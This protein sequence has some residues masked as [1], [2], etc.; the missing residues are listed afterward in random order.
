MSLKDLIIDIKDA[1]V[2]GGFDC[3]VNYGDDFRDDELDQAI[4]QDSGVLR[5]LAPIEERPFTNEIM[6]NSQGLITSGRILT[7]VISRFPDTSIETMD[8]WLEEL[9][10]NEYGVAGLTAGMPVDYNGVRFWQWRPVEPR[11]QSAERYGT[12]YYFVDQLIE[13]SARTIT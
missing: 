1:F 4:N 6:L 2:T 11:N 10:V 12:K 9:F 3:V 7:Y 5:V 13:F 8:S